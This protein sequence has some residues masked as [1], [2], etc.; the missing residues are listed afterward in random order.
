VNELRPDRRTSWRVI[1][2]F[3]GVRRRSYWGGAAIWWAFILLPLAVGLLLERLFDALD[4]GGPA[5]LLLAVV[6]AIELT[7]AA[8][9]PAMGWVFM[10]F[11]VAGQ[12]VLRTNV[13]RAQ[14][15]PDPDERGPAIGDP[16][17]ALPLFRED[18]QHVVRATDL[19]LDLVPDAVIG[20]VALVVIARIDPFVSLAVA[21]PLL[22][23]AATGHLL[24]P[25]VRRR[26][27]EDR[28]VTAEVTS[29][30]G[31]AF[32][33]IT[34][35]STSGAA[36]AVLE[37]VARLC[38]RRRVTAVRDRVAE[39]LLP[40]VGA[41]AADL[42]LAGGLLAAALVVGDDLTA[43]QV[44]LLASY[45]VLLAGLPRHWA[46]WLAAR[47]H[48]DV[49]ITRLRGV[50]R[51][52]DVDDLIAPVARIELDPAPV[53]RYALPP[54]P[55]APRIELRGVVAEAPDGT[56][57]GP[58]DLTVPAGGLG[59]ITGQ[60]GC[61]KSTLLRAVLGLAPL[62]AGEVRW[63]GEAVDLSRTMTPPRAAYV[64]Q[65]PTIF[66]EELDANLR[67]GW[68]VPD[69][70]LT[71]ALRSANARAFVDDL[72]DGLA[73]RLGPRGV[74]LS[75][76]QAHRIAAAR[77]LVTGAALVVAD[78]LSAALDAETEASLL[79]RL[80]ADRTRTLLLVS[81]RPAVIARAD[82]VATLG[83]VG[84]GT[85]DGQPGSTST[86]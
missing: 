61:G 74:R 23:A 7:R 1:R 28:T 13:L 14:L 80:L 20:I 77:A 43:G 85:P 55:P 15:H 68:A 17:A 26:R 84:P 73:T 40:S 2:H 67:L 22:A 12:T 82:A 57:V 76:G 36:P 51:D 86:P 70:G 41:A 45:A 56:F 33:A 79:D 65:V 10:P 62:R 11:F 39:Q 66:S 75:G 69:D 48:A 35:L 5:L 53:P 49:A 30:L 72:D 34:T 18:A 38:D 52:G 64:A 58:V 3:M 78:D 54:A 4:T 50:V 27:A 21:L 60:V 46:Q 47:R 6:T 63:N 44:A 25:L 42:A 19:W 71:T 32:G 81:H 16:S 24:A 29:F 37:R 9:L 8:A 83:R 31:E 59:V